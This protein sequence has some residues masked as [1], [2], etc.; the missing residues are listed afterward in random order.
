M[1]YNLNSITKFGDMIKDN[2]FQ[3]SGAMIDKYKEHAR[4][5]VFSNKVTDNDKDSK[6]SN[7]NS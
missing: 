7:T 4:S 3:K 6:T 5:S 1:K 2:L